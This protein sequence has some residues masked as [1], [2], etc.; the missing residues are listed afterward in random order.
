M[1]NPFDIFKQMNLDDG[2]KGTS[3]LAMSPYFLRSQS[4]KQ[5]GEV[6]M[7]VATESHNAISTNEAMCVMLVVNRAEYERLKTEA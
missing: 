1:G 5:G 4:T 6:T 7:G 3:N 2:A